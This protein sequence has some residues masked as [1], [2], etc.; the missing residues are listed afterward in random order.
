MPNVVLLLADDL[1]W[2]DTGYA[3]HPVL[4]TPH[5]D[6]LAHQGLRMDRFYAA[7]PVCSPTRGSCL[8]GRHP[9]RYGVLFANTGHLPTAEWTLAEALHSRGYATGHFGKWHLGTLT[10]TVVESNRGGPRGVEHFSPPGQHGFQRSFSTEAKVPTWDPLLRPQGVKRN[11]WWNPVSDAEQAVPY[12]TNYWSDGERVTAPLRGDDSRVI[13]DRAME[14][15]EQAA[16]QQRPF[17]AVVWFHAPHLPV[18]A[19]ERYTQLYPDQDDYAKHY[20]GCITAMDEQVGRLRAKLQE[21]NVAEDTLVFFASD[22]GPEGQQGKA[23]GS[24]GKLS[25]RKRSLREGGVR[26]PGLAFWPRVIRPGRRTSQ[27]CVT[28]DYLPTLC[29]VLDLEMPDDRPLDGVSL[30]PLLKGESW[31]RD[32][33]IAFESGNQVALIDGNLK[34]LG[35]TAKKKSGGETRYQLF[36]LRADPAEQHDLSSQRQADFQRMTAF[37][38]RWRAACERSGR[39]EDY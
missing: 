31:Q 18:V 11:T 26:V 9:F 28:S 14:F 5:L 27:P 20:F 25:G 36:D 19:A 15:I 29:D 24:A 22:N 34:L 39:G 4:K 1:G 10:R 30:L 37:L 16:G 33:P 3:G 13:V 32:K 21:C 35:Q 8:T 6:A 23:P 2:A 7:A 38:E 12:G 17:L